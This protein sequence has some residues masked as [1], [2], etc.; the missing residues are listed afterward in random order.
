MGGRTA[1][2]RLADLRRA[3]H[4]HPDDAHTAGQRRLLVLAT[5]LGRRGRH[6]PMI[7]D[8]RA[9]AGNLN[10]VVRKLSR[11]SRIA[12]RDSRLFGMDERPTKPRGPITLLLT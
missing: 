1:S 6:F 5:V 9:R 10:P 12:S 4:S 3:R 2:D 7:R 8:A 11:H